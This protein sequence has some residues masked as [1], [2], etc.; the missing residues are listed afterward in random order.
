MCPRE[1]TAGR[2]SVFITI[3][4]SASVGKEQNAGS[5][6]VVE[7]SAGP[8]ELYAGEE[9]RVEEEVLVMAAVFLTVDAPIG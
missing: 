8:R 3:A 7:A 1:V 5:C 9:V 2:K 4:G 6:V